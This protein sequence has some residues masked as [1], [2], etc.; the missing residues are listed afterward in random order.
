MS[1]AC[2]CGCCDY[3]SGN[4]AFFRRKSFGGF[5]QWGLVCPACWP[6][7]DM[8]NW[9]F[10]ALAYL[11]PAV[12]FVGQG[13]VFAGYGPLS[14]LLMILG[15]ALFCE[16][17]T[18]LASDLVCAAVVWL[19]GGY[20][21]LVSLGEGPA[22]RTY[23]WGE[24]RL[25]LHATL[26]RLQVRAAWKHRWIGRIAGVVAPLSGPLIRLGL[27]VGLG[28]WVWRH[29][30]RFEPHPFLMA[31]LAGAAADM[32]VMGA[33]S[34]R[35]R[36]YAQGAGNLWT[37]LR[38]YLPRPIPGSSFAEAK[39]WS[40]TEARRYAKALPWLRRDA[41]DYPANGRRYAALLAGIAR[42]EGHQAAVWEA[43]ETHP[44]RLASWPDDFTWHVAVAQ[45]GWSA[46]MV[47]GP[48]LTDLADRLSAPPQGFSSLL[49][50]RVRL[51]RGAVLVTRGEAAEGLA[52][53]R[54][55]LPNIHGWTEKAEVVAWI[56]RGMAEIEDPLAAEYASLA[57]H[58]ASKAQAA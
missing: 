43:A 30:D 22:V 58:L 52:L 53:L 19:S 6:A 9:S 48:E 2:R 25:D 8:P 11:W 14:S 24:R 55:A 23:R 57:A 18:R 40:L 34:L 1:K 32:V 20:I 13:M 44:V 35:P 15:F 46:I 3:E 16:P 42:A 56:A 21:Y 54:G 31:A 37:L 10:R 26:D 36:R 12:L 27:G 4:K 28:Y 41:N 29:Q 5:S 45:L 51:T 38:S 7:P 49:E 47:G 33:V 50:P 17:L 39:A